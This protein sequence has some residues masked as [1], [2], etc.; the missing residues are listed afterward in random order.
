[1]ERL[2]RLLLTLV[3][4]IMTTGVAVAQEEEQHV[5][6]NLKVAVTTD[7]AGTLFV[8]IQEQI[9]EL[10]ELYDVGELTVNG[11]LN[12]DDYNVIRNQLINITMLDLSATTAENGEDIWLGNW[13]SKL[14]RCLLPRTVTTIG[15]RCFENCDSLR[16]VV[17]PEALTAIPYSCFYSCTH[18]ESI[19]IPATVTMIYD[20]EHR[21]TCHGDHDL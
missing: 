14:R 1:M 3:V 5:P 9:E 4:Y 15:D 21:H 17:L 16:S 7:K 8:K 12:V 13:E 18:L 19:D 6:L 11:P 20:G 10:G 2:S